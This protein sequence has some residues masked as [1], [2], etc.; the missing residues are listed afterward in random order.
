M[1]DNIVGCKGCSQT[2]RLSEEDIDIISSNIT[3]LNSLNLVSEEVFNER[4][5]H[6][7]KCD[8]FQYGSTCVYCGCLVSIKTKLKSSK[9]PYPYSPRW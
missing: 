7:L 4:M 9:C 8:A 3:D 2:V 1:M 5:G 6:C